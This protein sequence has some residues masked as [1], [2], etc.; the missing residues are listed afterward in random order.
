MNSQSLVSMAEQIIANQA[1]ANTQDAANALTLH[2]K[3]FWAPQ[4]RNELVHA[5]MENPNRSSEVL[6]MTIREL[7]PKP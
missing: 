2:L 5:L 3:K 4:M 7:Q 6:D 1:I